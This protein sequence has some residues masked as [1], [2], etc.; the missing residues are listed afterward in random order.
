[1][2]AVFRGDRFVFVYGGMPASEHEFIP[3]VSVLVYVAE[4]EDTGCWG[5][6]VGTEDSHELWQDD[7]ITHTISRFCLGD[8]LSL[9]IV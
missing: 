3:G 4:A 9:L 8:L 2:R 5:A 1:M 7:D 6:S